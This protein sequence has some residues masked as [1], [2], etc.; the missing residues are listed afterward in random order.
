MSDLM[1]E[2]NFRD[3]S[4][5]INSSCS[6]H[7][8]HRLLYRSGQLSALTPKEKRQ[9]NSLGINT[10]L[11]LRTEREISRKPNDLPSIS[12]D[13]ENPDATG[14]VEEQIIA[15]DISKL[16]FRK[17]LE[18]GYRD[19]IRSKAIHESFRKAIRHYVSHIES[20]PTIVHCHAGKDRTGFFIACVLKS[21][22]IPDCAIIADYME[23]NCG[24][25]D[26]ISGSIRYFRL[27]RE[28]R[29]LSCTGLGRLGEGVLVDRFLLDAAWEEAEKQFGTV[30]AYLKDGLGLDAKAQVQL[31]RVLLEN[32]EPN[33]RGD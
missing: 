14:D 24:L 31:R 26:A 9:L 32:A 1:I 28:K 7:L 23:S 2:R 4:L 22:G 21:I 13:V 20:G 3:V 6:V 12:F 11:D 29:G 16:D 33:I 10:I 27:E 18:V 5:L 25:H 30:S 17:Q 15:G 19:M 8:R